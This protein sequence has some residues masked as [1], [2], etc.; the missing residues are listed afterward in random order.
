MLSAI[1][2][3]Q[4]YKHLAYGQLRTPTT[5]SIGDPS[6]TFARY[7]LDQNLG[8]LDASGEFAVL[9]TLERLE[10]IEAQKFEVMKSIIVAKT[11][12]TVFRDDALEKLDDQY[13]I[14]QL[15]LADMVNAQVN[16]VSEQARGAG[17]TVSEP[18]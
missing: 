6:V 9:Q 12:S 15:R 8:N 2:K 5:M 16:P 4:V 14:Y 18:G 11:G 1:Q 7:R 3:Q 13:L 10:C 17:T